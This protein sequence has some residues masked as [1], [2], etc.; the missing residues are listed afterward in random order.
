RDGALALEQEISKVDDSFFVKGLQMLVDGSNSESIRDMLEME[1]QHLQERHAT[2]KKI[3]EF[4]GAAA[5]AFGMIG[6]LIG[7][8]QMLCNMSDPSSIGSGMAVA[9]ITTFYGAIISNLVCIPLAGKLGI[10][11]KAESTA[12]E[13]IVEGVCAIA[14]G[15]NPTAVREKLHVFVSKSSRKEVK[16]NV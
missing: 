9:L 8:V 3:L 16:A 6:T 5:P 11:S 10:Y 14:E 12:M 1:I 13:M 2:G 7:L 15:E 4:M